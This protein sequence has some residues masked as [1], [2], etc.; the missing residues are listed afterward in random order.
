MKT[1]R[2]LI[3]GAAILAAIGTTHAQDNW[4]IRKHPLYPFSQYNGDTVKYLKQNFDG[5]ADFFYEGKPVSEFL[6]NI[7][8]AMPIRTFC[9]HYVVFKDGSTMLGGLYLFVYTKDELKRLTQQ[10]QPIYAIG[11][12]FDFVY[13]DIEPELYNFFQELGF[14]KVLPWTPEILQK[15]GHRKLIQGSYQNPTDIVKR[16]FEAYP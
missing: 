16:Y 10:K 12:E 11:L 5:G 1:L 6:D 7:D 13:P 3:A 9:P 14:R 8:P 2:L 4:I 15:I